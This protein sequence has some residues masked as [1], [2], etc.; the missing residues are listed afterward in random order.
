MK[1]RIL[2]IAAMVATCVLLLSSTGL[3][4]GV[5]VEGEVTRAPYM[6]DGIYYMAVD[7]D[8][9]RI[10]EDVKVERRYYPRKGAYNHK[11]ATL[12]AVLKY[13]DVMMKV[14]RMEVLRIIIL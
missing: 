3:G 12:S 9:Y 13:Q 10:L 4:I 8:T 7:G 2:W 1:N 11:K 14:N 6:K 5:W